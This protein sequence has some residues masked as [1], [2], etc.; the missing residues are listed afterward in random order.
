AAVVTWLV[1]NLPIL[2]LY[3][4][5]WYEFF[6]LNS[7]RGA[8]SDSLLRLAAKAVGTT[9]DVPILNIVSFGLMILLVIG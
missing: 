6:R 9:W 7:E 2:T 5:G 3:P 1:V 8:D 4:R